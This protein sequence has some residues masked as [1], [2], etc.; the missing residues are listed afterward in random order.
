MYY[1]VEKYGEMG[2]SM[3][4]PY[5]ANVSAQPQTQAAVHAT[6]PMAMTMTMSTTL[7]MVTVK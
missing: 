7:N 6:V 4:D 5:W 1:N 2:N 3:N